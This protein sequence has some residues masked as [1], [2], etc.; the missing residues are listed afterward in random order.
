MQVLAN[1]SD[2]DGSPLHVVSAKPN[3]KVT[4]AKV[5]GNIVQRHAAAA[6]RDLRRRLHDR[7]RDRA[8]RASASSVT[9][10]PKAPLATPVAS[11]TVLTLNDIAGSHDARRQRAGQRVLRRRAVDRP[12][13]LGLSG[14]RRDSPGDARQA[15]P[16]HGHRAQPDHPVQ[17]RQPAGPG[18]L[19]LRVHLGAR[20][21]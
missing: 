13:S 12:R 20:H 6:R 21:G 9:V 14:L 10:D 4:T 18:C 15:H 5:V 19:Q 7:E 3:D 11:D 16:G 17:G 2:P 1:D 8:A